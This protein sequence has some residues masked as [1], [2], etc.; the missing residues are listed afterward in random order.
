MQ[1]KKSMTYKEQV[2]ILKKK[3]LAVGNDGDV[4]N[5]LNHVN[6]YRLKN[7]KKEVTYGIVRYFSGSIQL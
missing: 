3:G 4:I 6:Y 5:F 7:R 1:L 2:E